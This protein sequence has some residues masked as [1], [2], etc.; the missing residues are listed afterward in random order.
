LIYGPEEMR[1]I[2]R[3]VEL[4]APPQTANGIRAMPH[5]LADA[6][7]IFSGWGGPRLDHAFL[8]AAP[9]LGAFFYGSGSLSGIVT[10]AVWEHEPRIAISTAASMNA[11][12]VS[13]Y[14]L[15]TILFSLK[16][17]WRLTRETR[18]RRTFSAPDRNAAPG[19][20]RSTVGL[21]SLGLIGRTVLK[22]LKPFDLDVLVYDPFIEPAEADELG[23]ACVSL[24]EMFARCDVVSLH[25]PDI[26][27]THRMITGKLLASMKTG[28]TFINTAR[29]MIVCQ[30]ELIEVAQRRPDL[31]FVL[32]VATPEPPE[33]GSPLYSLDNVVLTPHIAGSVSNECRRMGRFVVNELERY[34]SGRP[35][36]GA[37]TA[38]SVWHSSHR[39]F[40]SADG[41]V[42]SQ[43]A[44]VQ[45]LATTK[46][47]T[48]AS[49]PVHG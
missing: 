35:L 47:I 24:G 26:T 30:D 34:L 40:F 43:N 11:V 13:E 32:D 44:R 5:L 8:D 19:C 38:K 14:A 37:V 1:D 33:P 2:A 31:Q 49:S 23:V 29:P 20:Y 15:S 48:P 27:E 16:H 6:D 7:A 28:A 42:R 3:H 41:S 46:R 10:D 17:G 9:R 25:A 36:L 45:V 4:L 18:Q 22:L 12:P 21:I 39:P